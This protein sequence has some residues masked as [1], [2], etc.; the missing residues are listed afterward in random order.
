[1]YGCNIQEIPAVHK[2]LTQYDVWKVE[3]SITISSASV[4]IGVM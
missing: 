4:L 2:V 3:F 1:M